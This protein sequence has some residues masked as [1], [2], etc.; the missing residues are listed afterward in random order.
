MQNLIDDHTKWYLKKMI[1]IRAFKQLTRLDLLH[2]MAISRKPL[3]EYPL[4]SCESPFQTCWRRAWYIV[5]GKGLCCWC[6][7]GIPQ[8]EV[9]RER[10][11]NGLS[12]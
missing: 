6:K 1:T 4:I 11:N 5:N 9:E 7:E 3:Q 2:N 10:K 8:S 12:L